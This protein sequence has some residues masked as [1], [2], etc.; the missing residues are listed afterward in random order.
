MSQPDIVA[1]LGHIQSWLRYYDKH[2]TKSLGMIG[3]AWARTRDRIEVANRLGKSECQEMRSAMS[4]CMVSLRR[5]GIEPKSPSI[6]DV[7]KNGSTITV[8]GDGMLRQD[9]LRQYM[10][11]L[12]NECGNMS[13]TGKLLGPGEWHSQSRT[14]EEVS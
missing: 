13:P 5:I 4:A 7:R 12:E 2:I 10:D 14:S 8:E 1:H 9:M 6:W 11:R 3:K